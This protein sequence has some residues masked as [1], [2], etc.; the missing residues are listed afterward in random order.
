MTI[1]TRRAASTSTDPRT[2][3]RELHAGLAGENPALT[4]FYC[5]PTYDLAALGAELAALFGADAPLI[6]C[7][8][9]GEITPQ[10]YLE[11]SITGVAI[12]GPGVVVHTELIPRLR[13]FELAR[14]EAAARTAMAAMRAQGVAPSGATCFGFLL[15]DGLAMQEEMLV[16]SIY[17][18]LDGI[19]LIGGS[20]GDGVQFGSTH[21]YHRGRFHTDC[22]LFSL[23]ATPSAFRVFKTEHFAPSSGKMVVTG[24]EPARRIV[25]EIN[26]EPAAREYGR[27][28]GLAVDKLTPMIFAAHPVVVRVGGQNYVRSIQKVND[29][30]SLSFFCAID[31]GI[32]LTVAEG[33]D[34]VGNLE[35]AFAKVERELGPP[36]LVLGCDCILRSIE[37]GQ[38]G[39][40]DRIGA[41]FA[42]N[43]VVG[44]ATYGEQYNAMHVNQT[45]TGVAISAR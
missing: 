30:E 33:G 15:A 4:I 34:I 20:A 43:N 39:V 17:S 13:E 32:V 8:T 9:A 42:A 18:S 28:V 27:M 44:F 31:E 12:G 5:A 16:S 29:D 2:A 37:I 10:G 45:F 25:T 26:G 23:I 38:R 11:G 36:A 24:A 22:A 40:R 6:G 3:A 21:L 19:Q 35:D 14:G 41:I 7:T 1:Q